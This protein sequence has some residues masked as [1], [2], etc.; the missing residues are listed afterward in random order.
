[1]ANAAVKYLDRDV[2]RKRIAAFK[3]KWTK[4]RGLIKRGKAFGSSHEYSSPNRS[5]SDDAQA[6]RQDAQQRQILI[7]ASAC[8]ASNALII[9]DEMD[10]FIACLA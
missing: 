9:G 3:G 10:F 6:P 8:D 5:L 7:F 2:G 1:M 4:W